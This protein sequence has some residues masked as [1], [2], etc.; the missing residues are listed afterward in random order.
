MTIL[1]FINCYLGENCIILER[2]ISLEI[3]IFNIPWQLEVPESWV[4]SYFWNDWLES[5]AQGKRR[6]H[7]NS[8]EI[9]NFCE[10]WKDIFDS[11]LG[12]CGQQSN[13]LINIGD[14]FLVVE[15]SRSKAK[16]RRYR[17]PKRHWNQLK[18][19]AAKVLGYIWFWK[20]F[21]GVSEILSAVLCAKESVQDSLKTYRKLELYMLEVEREIAIWFYRCKICRAWKSCLIRPTLKVVFWR[22]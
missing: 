18:M 19:K 8:D 22:N 12:S 15:M 14:Y 10:I 13:Y 2:C 9:E 17:A 6:K 7:L 20:H 11:S 5:K 1:L 21:W 16:S 4:G 3:Y